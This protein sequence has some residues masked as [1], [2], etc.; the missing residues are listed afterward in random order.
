MALR[1]NPEQVAIYELIQ[2][3]A[4]TKDLKEKGYKKSLVDKVRAARSKGDA[5]PKAPSG[6]KEP[7]PGK[8]LYS[9]TLKT[10]TVTLDPIVAVRYDSVRHALELGDDYK[11]EQFIDES[12][13][14]ISELVGAVPP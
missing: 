13:D 4:K 5:P 8:P 7:P 2:S 6:E 3:G 14:I 1:W 12:T 11:L 10:T 9:A